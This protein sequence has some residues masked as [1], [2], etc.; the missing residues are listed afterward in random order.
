MTTLI[1][2]EILMTTEIF[3]AVHFDV[4]ENCTALHY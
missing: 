2:S 1:T 3:K 4:T